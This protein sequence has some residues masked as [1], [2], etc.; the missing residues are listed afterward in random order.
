MAV[1]VAALLAIGIFLLWAATA[2]SAQRYF[3]IDT[4]AAAIA[5]LCIG[6][7][8]GLFYSLLDFPLVWP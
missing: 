8:A 1:L 5:S 6:V 3:L 7:V 4:L 2:K